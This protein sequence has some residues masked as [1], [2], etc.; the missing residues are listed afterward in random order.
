MEGLPPSLPEWRLCSLTPALS[1]KEREAKDT[2]KK[3]I[4]YLPPAFQRDGSTFV[5]ELGQGRIDS[6]GSQHG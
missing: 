6:H 3:I 1:P 4:A 2:P 5:A